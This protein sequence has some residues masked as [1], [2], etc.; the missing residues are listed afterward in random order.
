MFYKAGDWHALLH[1]KHL[2]KRRFVENC[3]CAF[4][5]FYIFKI[6]KPGNSRCKQFQR[7][8]HEIREYISSNLQLSCKKFSLSDNNTAW[9]SYKNHDGVG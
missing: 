8:G 4:N 7:S 6:S 5:I 3:R 9:V 1:K 2:S